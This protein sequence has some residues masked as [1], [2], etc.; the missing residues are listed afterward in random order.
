MSMMNAKEVMTMQMQESVLVPA[1]GEVEFTPG[2]LHVM[3]VGLCRDLKAGDT[4]TLTLNIEN[5]GRITIQAPVK[6]P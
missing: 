5:S 3:L 1:R 4:I 6:E 2:G